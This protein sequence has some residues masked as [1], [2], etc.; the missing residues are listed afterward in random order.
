[1]SIGDNPSRWMGTIGAV[2]SRAGFRFI[3]RKKTWSGKDGGY[4]P[5]DSYIDINY[6]KRK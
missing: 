1:M 6:I 3:S 2:S 5:W 4:R